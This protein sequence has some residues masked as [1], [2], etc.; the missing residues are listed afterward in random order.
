MSTCGIIWFSYMLVT[1]YKVVETLLFLY[2]NKGSPIQEL[3]NLDSIQ[4]TGIFIS[5][6]LIDL[7]YPIS[8][9]L[10]CYFY[11]TG[12]LDETEKA[13]KAECGEG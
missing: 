6:L 4:R 10:L 9:L 2:I 1:M 7:I 5:Y 13:L 11:R 8:F 3:N 12:I